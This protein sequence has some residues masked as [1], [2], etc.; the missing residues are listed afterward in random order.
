MNMDVVDISIDPRLVKDTYV[1]KLPSVWPRHVILYA[2]LDFHMHDQNK[3]P[4]GDFFI[5]EH[6]KTT[7]GQVPKELS[8]AGVR[9]Q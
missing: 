4:A 6:V 9:L 5:S 3:L 8:K 1:C 7:G 2:D